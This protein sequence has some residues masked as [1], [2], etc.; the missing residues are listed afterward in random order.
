MGHYFL[1]TQYYIILIFKRSEKR[2]GT[3][4]LPNT[5]CPSILDLENSPFT[6]MVTMLFRLK[7]HDGNRLKNCY[8]T[9][10]LGYKMSV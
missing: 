4:A 8:Q 6:F 10:V 5:V 7:N 1:D 2:L 3:L 9:G